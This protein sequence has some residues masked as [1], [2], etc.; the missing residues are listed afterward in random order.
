[1]GIPSPNTKQA[2]IRPR[3]RF[4]YCFQVLIV[5]ET[6]RCC[7]TCC[8]FRLQ[9][10]AVNNEVAKIEVAHAVVGAEKAS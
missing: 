6:A 3:H 7:L 4:S 8:I 1:M 10:E 2:E 9:R 5:S